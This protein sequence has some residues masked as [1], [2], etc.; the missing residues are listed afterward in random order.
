MPT[1]NPNP[2]PTP[3]PTGTPAPS[4]AAASAVDPALSGYAPLLADAVSELDF[5]RSGLSAE[6]KQILDYADSRLFSNPNFLSSK[7][8]PDSWPSDVN[9]ALVRAI[10]LLMLEINITKKPDGRHVVNWEVDS[11]DRIL[12]GLGIYQGVCVSCYGKRDYNTVRETVDN[13]YP[14]VSDQNHV[15]REMLKTFA[16]L[17][18]ADGEGILVRSFMENDAGDFDFLYKRDSWAILNVG[19]ATV[20]EFG[21]RNL[22]FMNQ[23]RLPDGTVESFP[24]TV[25][26]IAGG[27]GSER[28][29]AEQ[30]FQDINRELIHFTGDH[31]DFAD[32]FR[33]YSQTPYTPE[34]GYILI[35][36]EAG[37]PS[38]HRHD[39]V[40]LP[41]PG[42]QGR[43]IL[44]P[45]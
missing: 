5:V 22:S 11:L 44:E 41:T 32:L 24:T 26:K 16:Y 29:A 12:D 18:L 36:G 15:H 40:G 10:P 35:V 14:I 30:W 17:A 25:F 8:G 34:P 39:S 1:A 19:S 27:A 37:S 28:E 2:T 7:W 31:E 45:G 43:A 20:T 23:I 3:P 21:W 42:P 4:P 6:E 38:F 13:H 33:S 9:M